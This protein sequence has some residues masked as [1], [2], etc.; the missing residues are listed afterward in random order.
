MF[1]KK[2][3][4]KDDTVIFQIQKIYIKDVSFESPHSPNIF[5][6][7]WNP[8]ISCDLNNIFNKLKEFLF[9]VTLRVIVKVHINFKLVFLCEVHQSGIFYIKGLSDKK[10]LYCLGVYCPDILFPYVRECVSSLTSRGGFP[11]LNLDPVNFD[12]IF[13]KNN[14][15]KDLLK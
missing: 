8:K 3:K 14:E 7:T 13:K 15:N 6:E 11:N 2:I 4:K 5:K 12:T 9:E 10:L 1:G